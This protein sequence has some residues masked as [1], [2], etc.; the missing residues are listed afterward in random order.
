MDAGGEDYLMRQW[1]LTLSA[2]FLTI[3]FVCSVTLF[4]A[5]FIFLDQLSWKSTTSLNEHGKFEGKPTVKLREVRAELQLGRGKITFRASQGSAWYPDYP[6]WANGQG[7]HFAVRRPATD[8]DPLRWGGGPRHLQVFGFEAGYENYIENLPAQPNVSS[9]SQQ[10]ALPIWATAI[11]GAPGFLWLASA[12]RRRRR[13][14]RRRKLGLCPRCG[15]DVREN[16]GRCS[17][18]GGMLASV[19]E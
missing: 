12:S 14:S 13:Q 11:A 5:S 16:S 15:Y 1:M 4:A 18:C 3:L 8:P 9:S 10:L 17:E 2:F 6:W 19:P 7:F